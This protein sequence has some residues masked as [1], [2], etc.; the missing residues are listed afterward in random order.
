MKKTSSL[1]PVS[2]KAYAGFVERINVVIADPHKR[3]AMLAALDKYLEGDRDAYACELPSDCVPIFGMLRF[4]I[5]LA[6]A[7]SEK[8]RM[9]AR[10]R[11]R[12]SARAVSAETQPDPR[13][14]KVVESGTQDTQA[15]MNELLEKWRELLEKCPD[16]EDYDEEGSENEEP[17]AAPKSRRQ[18]RAEQRC[19]RP[20]S[21]WRKL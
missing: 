9:R 3:V 4:D 1:R 17:L 2:R 12:S 7:R 15:A 11:K 20:K 21:R 14:S 8:A 16:D 6:M 10:A 5:D 19:A 18:R 13:D